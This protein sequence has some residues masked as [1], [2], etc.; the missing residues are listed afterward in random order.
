VS[1]DIVRDRSQLLRWYLR[2]VLF[3]ALALLSGEAIVWGLPRPLSA[4]LALT[5]AVFAL[6]SYAGERATL[7]VARSF[8]LSLA[9]PA[10]VATAILLPPP[11]PAILTLL[12]GVA[13][14]ATQR[15][16]SSDKK[17]FNVAHPTLVVGLCSLLWPLLASPAGR[18]L[19]ALALLVGLYYA[20][21]VGV[22]LTVFCL[23]TRRA[24]WIVWRETYR[25]TVLPELGT[26]ALGALAAVAW[27]AD[28]ALLALLAPPAWALRSAFRARAVAEEAR[29][30]AEEA[31]TMAE[32][33]RAAA[34]E[35][36]AAAEEAR[37]VAVEAVRV[38]DTFL[39]AGAHD[40]RTP[41]TV[42]AGRIGILRIRL[43][44]GKDMDRPWLAAQ[45]EAMDGAAH[46]MIATIEEMTDAAQLQMG[47]PLDLHPE[48]VDVGA[49]ARETVRMVAEA[50]GTAEG[51]VV[52]DAPP[53][54]VAA[55]D[56]RRLERA[57]QNV[58]GNALKYSSRGAGGMPV[59]VAV[60]EDDAWV[61]IVVRDRGVGIPADELPRIFE[62]FY[63][64]ST[65]GT[66]AGTGIGLA[67][68][69]AIVEQH[70]GRLEVESLVGHGTTVTMR[71][72]RAPIGLG[73]AINA[74]G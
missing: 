50:G 42:L 36:R 63:R 10:Q 56:R 53:G 59:E 24:P 55:S 23:Q 21:D 26:G 74:A 25:P 40:L 57:V 61:V 58:V 19:P 31:R 3:M 62:H 41:L 65:V 4:G 1:G 66:V 38:R 2:S 45:V 37:G 72:P 8:S 52:V 27:R 22:L 70:G 5:T 46:R 17:V 64:A 69:K 67:G 60:R 47:R 71:L 7:S 44:S 20:L 49:L 32:E 15:E 6:L 33:A 51:D 68:T 34:E 12:V 30:M 13:T 54:I 28:P 73:S 18:R 14:Q 39:T 43:S 11:L 29:T 16:I 48:S 35:A 9:T